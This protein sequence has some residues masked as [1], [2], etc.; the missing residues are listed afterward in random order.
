[1]NTDQPHYTGQFG[2]E[3][4]PT[5][6]FRRPEDGD[7][8]THA[9]DERVRENPMQAVLVAVGIGIALGVLVKA[10][11]PRHEESRAARLLSEIQDRLH[12][13]TDPALQKMSGLASDGADL[14]KDGMGHVS[15]LHLERTA[16]RIKRRLRNLFS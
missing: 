10:L 1:M 4:R 15:D 12:E 3:S 5:D 8:F 6:P 9:M 14:V 2:P 16:H 13:L 11:A 7:S